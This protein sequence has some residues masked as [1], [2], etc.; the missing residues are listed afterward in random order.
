MSR[1]AH[2]ENGPEM[3]KLQQLL[4]IRKEKLKRAFT[5]KP[6]KIPKNPKNKKTSPIPPRNPKTP[7]QPKY[8]I[9]DSQAQ[10]FEIY[11][12]PIIR[13]TNNTA[14]TTKREIPWKI[15]ERVIVFNE[16]KNKGKLNKYVIPKIKKK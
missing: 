7:P 13:N 12:Q 9:P 15:M 5:L 4:N 11:A 14:I 6:K 10:I 8:P 1:Q 2:W 16:I 3:A